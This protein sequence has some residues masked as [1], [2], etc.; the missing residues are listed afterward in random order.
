L[1]LAERIIP[2]LYVRIDIIFE[3][4]KLAQEASLDEINKTLTQ[5]ERDWTQRQIN[6][7]EKATK[8]LALIID[9]RVAFK[10]DATRVEYDRALEESKRETSEPNP[11]QDRLRAFQK[12]FND[13]KTFLTA[14]NMIRQRRRLTGRFSTLRPKPLIP[15]SLATPLTYIRT[16]AIISRP[17]NMRIRLLYLIPKVNM[18]IL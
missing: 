9:A 13:A 12:W 6:N 7:P 3:E 8:V 18:A 11:E 14:S 5:L 2:L 4:L 1:R 16:Q 15:V 17:S 10:T